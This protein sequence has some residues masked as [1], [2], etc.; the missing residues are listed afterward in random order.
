[1]KRLLYLILFL[2]Q[3]LIVYGQRNYYLTDSLKSVG[4][5]IID[6]G[7]IKNSTQ[8]QIVKKGKTLIYSPD[9]VKE[10][11]F[12]DGRVYISR[13][14]KINNEEK[15]VF[16]QRLSKGNMNLYYYKDKNGGKFFIEKDSG[17]LIEVFKKGIDNSNY[18]DFLK[19]YTQDCNNVSGALKLVTYNKPSL[20]KFIDQ[21]NSC[22]HK[23]FPF[24]KYGL[25]IGYGVSK[26]QNPKISVGVLSNA[27]FKNDNSFNAGIFAD[28][29]ILFSYFSLHPE[30]YF[31]KNKF[32]GHSI[33]NNEIN[34]ITINTT[35]I[36]IPLLIRYTY[37]ALKLRPYVNIG[38]TFTYNISGNNVVYA[39]TISD[40]IIEIEEIINS[41]V[42][43]EKQFGYTAG[44]GIQYSID[45]RK[46]LFL[47][48]RYNY[49]NG[50]TKETY[51]NKSFQCIIG[52]NF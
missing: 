16:L 49:L 30:I 1:M 2:I 25:I 28:I 19:P 3:S 29:P 18:R 13:I 46:S 10:Y 40:D 51:G 47:E 31:Q 26:P 7:A 32:S 52:I 44:G 43:S 17:Q 45:N 9:E 8:C 36:N 41:N 48:L 14:I 4:V 12:K 22:L 15:K 34:Y 42:Y 50:L 20:T 11:G 39:T 27:V 23:P 5:K 37:P 35:S 21:Y 6:G 33:I 38:G 24:I